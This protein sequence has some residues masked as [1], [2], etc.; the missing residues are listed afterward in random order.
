MVAPCFRL[1]I[2]GVQHIKISHVVACHGINI[3]KAIVFP[4]SLQQAAQTP[5][6]G[7]LAGILLQQ[8]QRGGAIMPHGNG[9]RIARQHALAA[10]LLDFVGFSADGQGDADNG[11]QKAEQHDPDEDQR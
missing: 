6:G 9:D 5:V 11:Q 1:H 7:G 10:S 8:A 3:L 2:L 4:H